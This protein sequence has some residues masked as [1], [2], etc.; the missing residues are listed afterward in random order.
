MSFNMNSNFKSSIK[1]LAYSVRPYEF[2]ADEAHPDVFIFANR[3]G[4]STWLAEMITSRGAF[5][6][7]DQPLC[8]HTAPVQSIGYM[9]LGFSGHVAPSGAQLDR[10]VGYLNGIQS[11][12]I[13]INE[14]WRFWTKR[15]WRQKNRSVYKVLQ[16][17]PLLPELSHR[18]NGVK[19]CFL[20]NPLSQAWSVLRAGWGTYVSVF[21]Q[22]RLYVER[23]LDA[24]RLKK[25]ESIIHN[26]DMLECLVLEWVLDK[27]PLLDAY[28]EVRK[29]C[30]FLSY[31]ELYLN[32][33]TVLESLS[34]RLFLDL[35]P[36]DYGRAHQPSRTAAITTKGAVREFGDPSLLHKWKDA[37]PAYKIERL[38]DLVDDF[39]VNIYSRID[40]D[41]TFSIFDEIEV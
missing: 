25:A 15:Y 35:Q 23:H 5:R 29:D 16:G 6:M 30:I 19:V 7:I 22:D 4:G 41:P 37:M 12:E 2:K 9:P 14:D 38:Y 34:E 27:L 20:R 28:S 32:S 40:H 11:G 36:S 1:H 8:I 39:G 26:G 17:M 3:R 21:L 18:L 33:H 31:E 13:R 24:S 10:V